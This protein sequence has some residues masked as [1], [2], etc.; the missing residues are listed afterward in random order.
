[1]TTQGQLQSIENLTRTVKM[2]QKLPDKHA[3]LAVA[4]TRFPTFTAE[5]PDNRHFR[6]DSHRSRMWYFATAKPYQDVLPDLTQKFGQKVTVVVPVDNTLLGGRYK[7]GGFDAEAILTQNTS[8]LCTLPTPEPAS[9]ATWTDHCTAGGVVPEEQLLSMDQKDL[10]INFY[11]QFFPTTM[12]AVQGMLM[13]QLA[14]LQKAGSKV[15]VFFPIGLLSMK[16][17]PRFHFAKLVRSY[18]KMLYAA[19]RSNAFKAIVFLTP[20]QTIADKFNTAIGA[21]KLHVVNVRQASRPLPSNL[22]P[23]DANIQRILRNWMDA[24]V[25]ATIKNIQLH[26]KPRPQP[27]PFESHA[28][29]LYPTLQFVR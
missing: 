26:T 24:Q 13:E 12:Q 17:I 6:D 9:H 16:K 8:Y 20:T 21:R 15:L 18:Q 29:R 28:I 11:T 1:M 19:Q 27:S 14:K 2:T 23:S 4:N 3:L 10:P 5:T 25:K 7:E 22:L